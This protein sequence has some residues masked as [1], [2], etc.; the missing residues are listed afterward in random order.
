[1]IDQLDVDSL[2]VLQRLE[3]DVALPSQRVRAAARSQLIQVIL[4]EKADGRRHGSPLHGAQDGRLVAS[5]MPARF[6]R[7]S[8]GGLR[9]PVATAATALLVVLAAGAI[10]QGHPSGRTTPTASPMRAILAAFASAS[11]DVV[12]IKQTT[13]SSDG[14]T[15]TIDTW[16]HPAAMP[17]EGHSVEWRVLYFG[18]DGKPVS[19][20]GLRYVVGSPLV[21]LGPKPGKFYPSGEILDVEYATRSWSD[22]LNQAVVG[23][24]FT[25]DTIGSLILSGRLAVQGTS[26]LDGQRVLELGSAV[27]PEASTT[28]WVSATTYL[29]V[30]RIFTYTA[31]NDSYQVHGTVVSDIS[32]LAPT[33]ADLALLTPDIPSGFTRTAAPPLLYP[34][35]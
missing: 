25:D 1:M 26:T 4:A 32:Y 10:L 23:P 9:L 19:D 35:G 18:P 31:G 22:Q 7:K 6:S 27:G 29:P 24:T 20:V 2:V 11:E 5:E 30:R 16:T 21:A 33:R 15:T 13:T 8:I 34:Q 17:P 28:L 14:M 12:Y 3:A